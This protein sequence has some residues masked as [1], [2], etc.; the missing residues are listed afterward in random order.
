MYDE[1]AMPGQPTWADMAGCH[2][3][4]YA[5][6]SQFVAGRRVLDAGFGGGYGSVILAQAGAAVTGVDVDPE[7]VRLARQRF[8][9]TGVD[10]LLD[11]CQQLSEVG[12]PFDVVCSFENIEHL[13]EPERF[14]AAAVRVLSP[15]GLLVIS[16]PDRASSPPQVDNRPRNP[17]H[18]REW[19][20]DEFAALLGRWFGAVEIRCQVESVALV[21]RTEAVAALRQA[22]MLANPLSTLL[23][24]KLSIGKGRE[25][26]WKKLEA[27]AGGSPSDYPVVPLSLV[28]VYG[29]P[30]CHVALCRQPRVV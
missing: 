6:A 14:L 25:R 10:Y 3:A 5:F 16:T 26:S 13:P 1:R 30:L 12:G 8:A 11:D 24:R 21:R 27:L 2:I 23:W 20:R 19:Y 29:R 28:E 18:L 4:R 17:F 15:D 7:A 22:L 9:G